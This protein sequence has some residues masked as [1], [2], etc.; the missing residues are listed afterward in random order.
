[1][2]SRRDELAHLAIDFDAMSV[3]L[4]A[5]LESHQTLLR[6]VSHE[7][8]SPLARMQIAL[9]L[10]RRPAANLPQ[11]LDRIEREAQRLD[12]LIGEI[13][14]LCRLDDPARKMELEEV[15]LHELLEQ[16][17]DNARVEAEPRQITVSLN[18]ASDLQLRGDRE[19][20]YRA[21]E[22]VLRNA[23]RFSPPGGQVSVSAAAT[24]H[25]VQISIADQG[26]G[27]PTESLQR[28]FEPFYRVTDA[29]DRDSGGNGVGLAITARVVKLHEGTMTASNL[30]AGGLQ[31]LIELATA[32]NTSD[33][34]SG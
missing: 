32:H 8:R 30:P 9:G 25:M 6:D 11:E 33:P 16:L 24:Q 10:A 18:C 27:V 29:R 5:L 14:S 17:A 13:M 4:R 2:G 26:P 22:N 1:V 15:N 23:V 28:I 20:L 21:L 34:F 7:L 3:R 31:V 12:D 19:L